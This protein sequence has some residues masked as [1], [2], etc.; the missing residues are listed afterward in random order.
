MTP[1]GAWLAL[2]LLG[3]AVSLLLSLRSRSLP[4]LRPAT[5]GCWIFVILDGMRWWGIPPILDVIAFCLLPGV[6]GALVLRHHRL[7]LG[8][9]D[10]RLILGADGKA[11]PPRGAIGEG[12][13]EVS[14]VVDPGVGRGVDLHRG[15]DAG[16]QLDAG[17]PP[18]DPEGQRD[19]A[20]AQS[21]KHHGVRVTIPPALCLLFSLALL[22]S[23]HHPWIRDHWIPLLQAPRLAVFA[24]ALL[25]ALRGRPREVDSRLVGLVMALSAGAIASGGAWAS[26]GLV[27]LL[28][29]LSWLVVA[30][31]AL[32][33]R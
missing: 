11:G 9:G 10:D 17:A 27:Q 21:A 25:V 32:L 31:L 12:D 24:L 23:R 3:A 6:W 1:R 15:I 7:P 14:G 16:H 2:V 4:S 19:R 26:L 30:A 5:W 29:G 22:A 18:S 28:S 33:A 8:G 20:D 13:P